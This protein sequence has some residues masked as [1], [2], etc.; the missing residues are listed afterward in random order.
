MLSRHINTRDLHKFN[1]IRDSSP[2]LT[3]QAQPNG[4]YSG[5]LGMEERQQFIINLVVKSYCSYKT[6]GKIPW[7][8]SSMFEF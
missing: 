5:I 7:R 4:G 6:V 2:N 1:K 8:R 3:P